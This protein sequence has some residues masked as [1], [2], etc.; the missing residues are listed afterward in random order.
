MIGFIAFYL[1][2]IGSCGAFVH[3]VHFGTV[4][5]AVKMIAGPF[6]RM[7]ATLYGVGDDVIIEE[8]S[9]HIKIHDYTKRT[10]HRT[11]IQ[12]LPS[13]ARRDAHETLKREQ[14]AG[15]DQAGNI[16]LDVAV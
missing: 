5:V 16:T 2:Q 6:A 3:Q 12:N 14:V 15:V 8:C 13:V 1:P 7:V 4:A 9:V 11:V 10:R